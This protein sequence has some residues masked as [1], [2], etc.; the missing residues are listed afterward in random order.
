MC[1]YVINSITFSS[2]DRRLL[3]SL[4]KKVLACYDSAYSGHNLVKDLMKAHGYPAPIW[5]NNTDHFSACD[6]FVINKNGV[7]YFQCETTSA[8]DESMTPFIKML[9]EKYAKKIHLSFCSEGANSETLVVKDETGVFYKE[10]FKLEW[11]VD[12]NSE[13]Q[14]FNAF[15]E[16][17][18]YL[19]E[20]FPKARFNYYDTLE[21][22]KKSIDLAYE[23]YNKEYFVYIFRFKEYQNEYANYLDM[24]EVA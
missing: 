12:G 22:I 11:C 8:W 3:K 2:R 18:E 24:R 1:N 19:K 17:F 13:N 6:E 15:S 7:Y 23:T 21:G 5:V 4:H 20:K 10:R 9:I 14:Y 16:L